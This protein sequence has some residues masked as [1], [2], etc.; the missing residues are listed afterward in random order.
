MIIKNSDFAFFYLISMMLLPSI[1]V[2]LF[3]GPLD[4]NSF[5]KYLD[6]M[7][8]L[9]MHIH[10][11]Y[12][13]IN[14]C[15]KQKAW[16]VILY[17]LYW[18]W[19]I[20][21]ILMNSLPLFH[22]IQ[23]AISGQFFVYFIFYYY[24]SADGKCIF[25][26]KLKKLLY[27][28]FFISM[29]LGFLQII[30][31]VQFEYFFPVPT[32]LRGFFGVSINSMFSSRVFYA[33]F[34]LVFMLY[35]AFLYPQ[36]KGY[37]HSFANKRFVFCML[38]LAF[39]LI[40]LTGSRKELIFSTLIL[41]FYFTKGSS[42]KI[43]VLSPVLF[44]VLYFL[45][46]V[47]LNKFSE[48][49]EVATSD[50]Y[51]RLHIFN[52]AVE[53][54]KDYFPFGSGPGTYGSIMSVSYQNIY[55]HYGVGDNILGFAGHGRGPIFDMYLTSSIAEIGI[56]VMFVIILFYKIYRKSRMNDNRDIRIFYFLS[57]TLIAFLSIMTPVLN[58]WIGFLLLAMLGVYLLDEKKELL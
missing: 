3:G 4:V 6:E 52:F 5:I 21:L 10:V 18:I 33:D 7:I 55:K 47:F 37:R 2:V 54:M 24:L 50:N 36:Q 32:E 13:V 56:G 30:F 45:G 20:I 12:L 16:P 22:L 35:Q 28:T 1:M 41:F 23:I 40:L 43:F 29:F 58:N 15:S 9:L 14:Q 26:R 31:P 17:L 11:F 8:I 53:I 49:N 57:I 46:T 34:L 25:Q 42:K 48:V 19:S 44:P 27:A 51:V 38:M 39:F